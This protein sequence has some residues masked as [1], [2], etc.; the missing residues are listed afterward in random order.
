MGLRTRWAYTVG[1]RSTKF[2]MNIHNNFIICTTS[3]NIKKMCGTRNHND[4]RTRASPSGWSVTNVHSLSNLEL[5][6][7]SVENMKQRVTHFVHKVPVSPCRNPKIL[8][9]SRMTTIKP[10][11]IIASTGMSRIP[12][13]LSASKHSGISQT[14]IS[15]S[16]SLNDRGSR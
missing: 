11:G 4:C 9:S 8:P 1:R 6:N 13:N 16:I 5:K 3:T 12:I 10:G 7:K 2:D 14:M 15:A